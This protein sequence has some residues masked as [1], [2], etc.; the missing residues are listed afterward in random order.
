MPEPRLAAVFEL[1]MT[2]T[3][4]RVDSMDAETRARYRIN[5]AVLAPAAFLPKIYTVRMDKGNF[6]APPFEERGSSGG[7]FARK[8]LFRLRF[9]PSPYPPREEWRAE[10][11]GG[12]DSLRMWEWRDFCGRDEE[13]LDGMEAEDGWGCMVF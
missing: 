12:P 13:G 9:D 4:R 7:P 10:A 6:R 11:G 3:A 1:E 8:F 5:E 2:L